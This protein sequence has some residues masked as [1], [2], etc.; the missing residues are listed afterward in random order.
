MADQNPF[1]LEERIVT[2]TWVHERHNTGNTLDA[3]RAKFKG[4]FEK[5]PPKRKTMSQWKSKLFEARNAK[6]ASRLEKPVKRPESCESLEQS[7]INSPLKSTNKKSAELGIP[8]T[9]MLFYMLSP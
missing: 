4:R 2:S 9:T 5:N 7:I 1:T 3:I 8:R 6:D